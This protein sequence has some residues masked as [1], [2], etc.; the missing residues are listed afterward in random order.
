MSTRRPDQRKITDFAEN[1]KSREEKL[2][3]VLNGV[4]ELKAVPQNLDEIKEV[5]QQL[6]GEV[7]DLSHKCRKMEEELK[8]QKSHAQSQFN[9]AEEAISKAKLAWAKVDDLEQYSRRANIRILNLPDEARET[10]YQCRQK[11]TQFLKSK[12]K[13]ETFRQDDIDICHRIGSFGDNPRP[14]IV[15]FLRRTTKISVMERRP[16]GAPKGTPFVVDDL[17]KRRR[18]LLQKARAFPAA[19]NAWAWKGQ[20]FVR[21]WGDRV[22]HVTEETEWDRLHDIAMESP[23]RSGHTQ[24][25]DGRQPFRFGNHRRSGNMESTPDRHVQRHAVSGR[26]VNADSDRETAAAAARFHRGQG[27]HLPNTRVDRSRSSPDS[28]I[29]SDSPT[30]ILRDDRCPK[31]PSSTETGRAASVWDG[32]PHEHKMLTDPPPSE[33]GDRGSGEEGNKKEIDPGATAAGQH[34]AETEDGEEN[35][36]RKGEDE[37][38]GS[39]AD[40]QP[41]DPKQSSSVCVTVSGEGDESETPEGERPTDPE[42]TT[43]ASDNA[44]KL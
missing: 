29:Q 12:L 17:T 15:K 30:L 19:R 28:P 42:Q 16:K 37:V 35:A 33:D 31:S 34:P 32:S 9:R 6:R 22:I 7:L 24:Q 39:S 43:P 18:Q 26:R 44:S 36:A 20:I 2:D 8:H 13:M 23:E 25:Q 38:V 40:E 4:E 11:V 5:I 10:H 41:A 27:M 14:I 21:L 1:P 3:R